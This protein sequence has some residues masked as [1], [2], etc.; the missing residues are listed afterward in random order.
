MSDHEFKPAWWLMNPH[1]QTI[2][3]A[4]WRPEVKNLLLE[5]ER[6]EL[7][8]GDFIDIDWLDKRKSGPLV[9]ILHG[10]EG[11]IES[12]YAKG[13]LASIG[14]AGWRGAFIH[15][16]GCSGIPNRLPR[17]YHSGET[18][19]IDYIVKVLRAREKGVVLA[20]VGYSL[21]GNVLL[22]WLGETGKANPLKAAI[23]I[24]VPFELHK[25]AD[26]IGSGFSRFYEWYL[27]KCA[28][29][30]LLSK[31]QKTPAPIDPVLLSKIADIRDFD[32]KY[33]VPVHG[34]QSVDEYYTMCSS[35]RFLKSI[36]VPTLLI[37]SKDDPFMTAEVIPSEEELSD[38]VQLEVT[39]R[40]GHVGFVSGRYPWRPE[41]WLEER[42]PKFLREYIK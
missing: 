9:L 38:K 19:D 24:S 4:V 16:R 23:A 8:D 1:L 39:E 14:H 2:W 10:F 26:K 40:G 31:F 15:F 29:D 30:R 20:G 42:V 12:H 3:P 36:E 33:T 17:G 5:R 32:N 34:F 27:I 7:P 28:C 41:F 35:R 18:N 21:G 37:Q 11:S 22:K 13:M 25:A 6:I